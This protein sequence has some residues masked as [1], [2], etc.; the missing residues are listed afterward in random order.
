M[1]SYAFLCVLFKYT[2]SRKLGYVYPIK[3]YSNTV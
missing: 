2:L 1:L 3:K